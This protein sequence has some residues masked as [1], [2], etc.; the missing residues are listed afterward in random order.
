MRSPFPLLLVFATLAGC[1]S[2]G[3]HSTVSLQPLEFHAT[4]RYMAATDHLLNLTGPVPFVDVDGQAIQAYL[5]QSY[6]PA[7][8]QPGE[9]YWL[10]A[11]FR[12]IAEQLGCTRNSQPGCQDVSGALWSLRGQPA[13][14]G[15]GLLNRWRE[16]GGLWDD[17]EDHLPL[18]VTESVVH[19]APYL[20]VDVPRWHAPLVNPYDGGYAFESLGGGFMATIGPRF[21]LTNITWG[22]PLVGADVLRPMAPRAPATTSQYIP[23][24]DK[25]WFAH[26]PTPRQIL[27]AVKSSTDGQRIDWS[28]ACVDVFDMFR[29]QQDVGAVAAAPIYTSKITLSVMPATNRSVTF[30][31]TWSSGDGLLVQPMAQVSAKDDHVTQAGRNDCHVLRQSPTLATPATAM[32]WLNKTLG[33]S[34][35][36][37]NTDLEWGFCQFYSPVNFTDDCPMYV[38]GYD[39]LAGKPQA[40]GLTTFVVPNLTFDAHDGRLLGSFHLNINDIIRAAQ[41]R[42]A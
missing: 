36:I 27:D 25:P 15:I 1:T 17:S 18:D 5:L 14:Y 42:H 32:S 3:S 22:K 12:V 26:G 2:F 16:Q 21:T 23:E 40:P 24:D 33:S 30:E 13:P 6:T 8:H 41:P 11:N 10:D 34:K 28:K 19:G 20:L 38:V 4:I 39:P 7:D 35:A 37:Y 29:P 31:G 9:R